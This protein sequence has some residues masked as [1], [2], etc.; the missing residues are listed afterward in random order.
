M[1]LFFFIFTLD[2]SQQMLP[3]VEEG[4]F[5][6]PH[7]VTVTDTRPTIKKYVVNIF[8][9]DITREY[10]VTER[11]NSSQVADKLNISQSILLYK[12]TGRTTW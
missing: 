4:I 12:S 1:S 6:Q 8:P 7:L 11:P 10:R 5:P 9:K 2:S 3:E